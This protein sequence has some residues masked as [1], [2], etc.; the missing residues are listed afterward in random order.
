[1]GV[2]QSKPSRKLAGKEPASTQPLVDMPM[3]HRAVF[4]VAWGRN[5]QSS[6]SFHKCILIADFV[7]KKV[8]RDTPGT[9]Y[10]W[11]SIV[12]NVK[13]TENPPVQIREFS[14]AMFDKGVEYR[15]SYTFKGTTN[16]SDEKIKLFYDPYKVDRLGDN[17]SVAQNNCRD[18]AEGVA[19][20]LLGNTKKVSI[21]QALSNEW[22]KRKKRNY[23]LTSGW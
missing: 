17:Y 6:W 16:W 2:Q 7:T 11:G 20:A 13:I 22:D 4:I 12:Q 9:H 21:A 19:H 10:D 18:V 14:P 23:L 3:P 8:H 15:N 1:M 5:G